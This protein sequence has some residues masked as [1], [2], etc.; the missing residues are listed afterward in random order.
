METICRAIP[1]LDLAKTGSL[2]LLGPRQ[3]GKSS[4]IRQL[5]PQIY[6]INLLLSDSYFRYQKDPGLLSRE[7][8]TKSPQLIAIDEIQRIP[9]LLNEIQF[10]IDEIGHRF[11]L[12]GSSARKLRKAGT[13]LL[14]GRASKISMHP[15]IRQELD[16]IFDLQKVLSYGLLPPVYLAESDEMRTSKLKDYIGLYLQEEIQAEA[17][18]RN[19]PAFS[20]FLETAA[21]ANGQMINFTKMG[22]DAQIAPST[23]VEYFKVLEDTLVATQLPSFNETKK[24]KAITTAKF[25]FFD[26]GIVRC[27]L[28]KGAIRKSDSDF[29]SYFESYLCQELMAYTSYRKLSPLKYWRSTSNFEVDF[30]FDDRIGIEIKSTSRVTSDDLKGLK[31]LQEEELLQDYFLVSMDKVGQQWN[32]VNCIYY[33]DFLDLLAGEQI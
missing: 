14:G 28:D 18:V 32:G 27:L 9:E 1:I 21:H 11:I 6:T 33:E 13:N 24:R 22:N 12:T 16:E 10:L 17:M 2:F 23:V 8:R 29:G 30:I 19:L 26:L 3:T 31:A 7:L 5:F 4:L 20:R 25:Y 15:F